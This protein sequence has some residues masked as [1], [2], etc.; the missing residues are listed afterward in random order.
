MKRGDPTD[1]ALMQLIADGR[2]DA[3]RQLFDRWKL[4]LLNFL[5]RSTGNHADA[6]DLAMKVFEDVWK[7]AGQY[8]ACGT[9]AAWLFAIARNKL[10]QHWRTAAHRLPVMPPLSLLED[11]QSDSDNPARRAESEEALVLAL[12]ALPAPQREA[13]LLSIHS[14]LDGTQLAALLGVSRQHFHVLVHRARNFL[15]NQ[16]E[17]VSS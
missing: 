3:F 1:D 14:Q 10:K 16:L 17:R 2:S 15:L 11:A 7:S 12:Q 6:E 4:P 8:A 13:L 9:F 5:F